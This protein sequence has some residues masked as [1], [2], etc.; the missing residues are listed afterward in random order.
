MP[1]WISELSEKTLALGSW[2]NRG[3]VLHRIRC[4]RPLFAAL[5]EA[6][7]IRRRSFKN[8]PYVY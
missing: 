5:Q 2:V 6:S 3:N 4:E 1:S 8:I 7:H